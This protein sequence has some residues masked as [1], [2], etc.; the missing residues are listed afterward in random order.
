MLPQRGRRPMPARILLPEFSTVPHVAMIRRRVIGCRLSIPHIG[1]A[2][3]L[4]HI[5]EAVGVRP[6]GYI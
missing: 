3:L 4:G 5:A 6:C 2:L 1:E